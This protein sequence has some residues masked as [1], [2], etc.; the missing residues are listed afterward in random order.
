MHLSW[1]TQCL[2]LVCIQVI[3]EGIGVLALSV[4]KLFEEQGFL[5]SVL[6][7]LLERL[8]CADYDVSSTTDL[9]L[10]VVSSSCGYPSVSYT[11]HCLTA[12]LLSPFFQYAGDQL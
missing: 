10:H 11:E 4:G 6:Y 3:I 9:V 12:I 2:F 8:G 5:G 7:L 1:L